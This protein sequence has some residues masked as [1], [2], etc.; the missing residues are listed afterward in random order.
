MYVGMYR[1]LVSPVR[2]ASL[3]GPRAGWQQGLQQGLPAEATHCVCLLMTKHSPPV[4][5]ACCE[6]IFCSVIP[7][8]E[9]LLS[10]LHRESQLGT[11]TVTGSPT[12]GS[13]AAAAASCKM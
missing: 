9:V 12:A 4:A 1:A 7:Q 5:V 13:S 6:G 3:L 2:I 11:P 8:L 10:V